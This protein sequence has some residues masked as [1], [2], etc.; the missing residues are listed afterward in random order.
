[1]A[2]AH[3]WF[4]VLN[5]KLDVWAQWTHNGVRIPYVLRIETLGVLCFAQ[6][7]PEG[8]YDDRSIYLKI[9]VSQVTVIRMLI[10]LVILNMCHRK[11]KNV[12]KTNNCTLSNTFKKN[13][14]CTSVPCPITA[15][16]GCTERTLLV[17]LPV[18]RHLWVLHI[19]NLVE[20]RGSSERIL[21]TQQ[22]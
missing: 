12:L 10:A 11:L 13:N 2:S 15:T 20:F 9:S 14:I 3:V 4:S 5:S 7:Q 19:L 1:M 22:K 21:Y 18:T 6:G 17:L 8:K 16:A